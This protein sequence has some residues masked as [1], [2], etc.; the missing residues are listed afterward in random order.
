MTCIFPIDS[1]VG[2]RLHFARPLSDRRCSRP[3]AADPASPASPTSTDTRK[4]APRPRRGS[5]ASTARGRPIATWTGRQRARPL[6]TA[7]LLTYLSAA[8]AAR[9]ARA[10][11][12]RAGRQAVGVEQRLRK[13]L[14]GHRNPLICLAICCAG[15]RTVQITRGYAA[16]AHA[17]GR[18][19]TAVGQAPGHWRTPPGGALAEGPRARTCHVKGPPG[20]RR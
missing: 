6:E 3:A 13:A 2:P 9:E 8:S 20:G 15:A 14:G 7:A 18:S 11:A 19:S 16:G 4:P 10:R 12:D 5:A 17:P 1:H